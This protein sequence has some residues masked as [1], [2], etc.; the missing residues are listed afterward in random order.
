MGL[1]KGCYD[2]TRCCC[3]SQEKTE[4]VKKE[5]YHSLQKEA[6][7]WRLLGLNP[8]PVNS[9]SKSSLITS[10]SPGD[11]C[12]NKAPVVPVKSKPTL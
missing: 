9:K 11:S 1:N 10:A 12:S 8:S 4:I 3:A 6:S 5:M 2:I 7:K